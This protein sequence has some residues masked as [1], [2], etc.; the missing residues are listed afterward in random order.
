MI[1]VGLI[2]SIRV[3][4]AVA[5]HV[6][7]ARSTNS[8]VNVPFPVKVY[9]VNQLL[10]V[11]VPVSSKLIVATTSPLVTVQEVGK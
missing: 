7:P 3:T 1:A 4:V 2:V 6:F 10:F 9:Q 8:K 5:L 11:I